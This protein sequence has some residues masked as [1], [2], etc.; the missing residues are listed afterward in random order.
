MF[1]R[2]KRELY[3]IEEPSLSTDLLRMMGP[4]NLS[5]FA[6]QITKGMEFLISR[7]VKLKKHGIKYIV[8]F[9]TPFKIRFSKITL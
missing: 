2:N 6:L 1:L 9:K 4:K 7:K 3:N 8:S 5:L